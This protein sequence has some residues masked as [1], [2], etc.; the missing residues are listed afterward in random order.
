MKF[1]EIKLKGCY[2]IDLD[3]NEDQRGSLNRFF[4]QK[5]LSLLLKSKS[6]C[7]INRTLSEKKGW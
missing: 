1:Q 3:K 7:Q 4:C 2:L 6:I 5:T